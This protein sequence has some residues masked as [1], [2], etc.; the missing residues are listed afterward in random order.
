MVDEGCV[1]WYVVVSLRD[2][3]SCKIC[4]IESE[5][6]EDS[7]QYVSPEWFGSDFD[8]L[9]RQT[10]WLWVVGGMLQAKISTYMDTSDS[11]LEKLPH[12]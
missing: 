10:S 3:D 4:G 8:S 6:T 12:G 7:S 1:D 9:G 11:F 5:F 2:D